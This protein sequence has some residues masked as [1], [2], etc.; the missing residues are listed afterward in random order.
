VGQV[1][2]WA[3]VIALASGFIGL[4]ISF[5][6]ALSAGALAALIATCS[7]FIVFLIKRD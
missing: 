6:I 5:Y 4:V 3:F 1:I 7:Y 2:V